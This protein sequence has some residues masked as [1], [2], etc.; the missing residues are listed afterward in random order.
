M[1]KL[2]SKNKEH[3]EDLALDIAVMLQ[4][5][6][7]PSRR[8][9]LA[10]DGAIMFLCTMFGIIFVASF[11]EDNSY[12]LNNLNE[13]YPDHR[14]IFISAEKPVAVMREEIILSFMKSG[15]MQYIR[16]NFPRQFSDLIIMQGYAE[17]IINAR[18]SIW[19]GKPC[20]KYLIDDN[21]KAKSFPASMVLA[22]DA[23]FYDYMPE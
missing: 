5:L 1:D 23:A 4:A 16:L 17:K 7:V 15:Y 9:H 14:Y 3:L 22:K 20:Y 2:Q 12:I 11:K 13:L 19:N 18:L 8:M 6:K 21:I 10:K